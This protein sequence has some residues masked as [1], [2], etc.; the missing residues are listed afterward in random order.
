[1]RAPETLS[2]GLHTHR[3]PDWDSVYLQTKFFRQNKICV[4]A[5]LWIRIRKNP[6]VLAGSESE[7]S[8]DADPHTVVE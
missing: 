6:K 1:M 4:S 3:A 7:K 8:S 5:V 2:T